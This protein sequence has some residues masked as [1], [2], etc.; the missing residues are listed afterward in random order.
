DG[1]LAPGTDCLV[2]QRYGD[3]DSIFQISGD[4]ALAGGVFDQIDLAGTDRHLLAVTDLELRAAAQR[5]DVLPHRPS[6]P[7]ARR[8]GGPRTELHAGRAEQLRYAAR[9]LQF[10]F[11]RSALAVR[12]G[13]DARDHHRFP[14]L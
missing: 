13:V 6:V 9:Q 7:V 10:D 12:P 14:R 11:L 1:S 5:D 2:R 3:H 4:V 8:R